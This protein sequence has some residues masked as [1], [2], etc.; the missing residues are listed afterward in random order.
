MAPKKRRPENRPHPRG[1]RWNHGAWR[2][3]VP[4]GQEHNWDN[5]KEFKLGT[6]EAEAYRTFALRIKSYD[7]GGL[8]YM[9]QLITKYHVEVIPKKAPSTQRSNA[10]S[11]ERLRLAFEGVKIAEIEPHLIYQYREY[12]SKKKSKKHYNLDHEVLSHMFTKAI[13]WGAINNHPMT[14]KKVVKFPTASRSRYVEDWELSEL[15]SVASPFI[16][17]YVNLKGLLGLD[18]GDMLSITRAQIGAES[19]TV[20]P[21]KKT[22]HKRKTVRRRSFPYVDE[23]GESTGVKEA[24]D[25]IISIQ[26]KVGSL[27]LFSTRVGQPYIKPDGTTSGFDS[28]WRRV[29]EKALNQTKLTERFTEHD[30][31]AK[32]ASDAKTDEEA[33]RQMDH[34]STQTTLKTYR[35]KAV[36]MPVAEGFKKD[37]F[38]E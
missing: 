23:N 1:W 14:N 8:I 28:I 33:R 15:L 21:R 3:R 9:D 11:I 31:R 27:Y 26:R 18:K 5:K 25:D 7:Q 30:L 12:V 10:F 4:K 24:L 6:T 13:E 35:R 22:K 37:K 20:E 38:E 16:A 32:V 2:Y 17:A 34:M 36:I 29:M 19:L